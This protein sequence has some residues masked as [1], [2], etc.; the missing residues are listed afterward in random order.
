MKTDAQ[1]Q[2]EVIEE[3]KYEA[4]VNEAGIGVSVKDG[5]VVT[6]RLMDPNRDH[7]MDPL[8]DRPMDPFR[9]RLMDPPQDRL[10]DPL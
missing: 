6:D 9:D 8:W 1:L 7:L 3:L 5:I 2:K 4:T 10:M